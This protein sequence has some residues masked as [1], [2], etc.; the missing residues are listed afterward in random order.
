MYAWWRPATRPTVSRRAWAQLLI[1][2]AMWGAVYPLTTITLRE[3]SPVVVVF[4]RVALA[5]LLLTPVAVRRDALRP[6]WKRPRAIIE[7]VLTQSTVPLLL[8]T[9]GQLHVA[10]GLAGILVGRSRCLSRSWPTFTHPTNG[11]RAGKARSASVWA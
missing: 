6:L 4:A 10:P 2:A 7:T 11:R 5:A 1:L 3:L 9:F 8:L